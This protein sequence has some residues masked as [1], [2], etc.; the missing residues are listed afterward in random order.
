ML[1][2]YL[3]DFL[4]HAQLQ[5]YIIRAKLRNIRSSFFLWYAQKQFLRVVVWAFPF[6]SGFPLQVLAML[7]AFPCNP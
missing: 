1:N 2:N 6:G 7:W 3:Y 4:S 5:I